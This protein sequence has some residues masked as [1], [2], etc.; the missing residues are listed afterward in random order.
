MKCIITDS[1]I[2][3][4]ALYLPAI[5]FSLHSKVTFRKRLIH[6]ATQYV[7]FRYVYE[8]FQFRNFICEHN[9]SMIK[10]YEVYTIR[11]DTHTSTLHNLWYDHIYIYPQFAKSQ[12]LMWCRG[13]ISQ[14]L[15]ILLRD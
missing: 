2:E 11:Y 15:W 3:M 10:D 7:N 9:R 6:N 1:E 8:Q 12:A 4:H 14:S 5:I 13:S